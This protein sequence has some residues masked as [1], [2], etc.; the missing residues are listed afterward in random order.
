MSDVWKKY[1][2]PWH[3]KNKKV[4]NVLKSLEVN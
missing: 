2:V 3:M 1:G 4:Q